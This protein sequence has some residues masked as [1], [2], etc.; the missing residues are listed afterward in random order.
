MFYE[1]FDVEKVV[2]PVNVK[3]LKQL[4]IESNYDKKE[5]DFLISGFTHGFSLGYEG[6]FDVKLRA[7]N[8]RLANETEEILLWNKVMKEVKE[9]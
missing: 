6:S 3:V 2:T 9:K 7:P 5:T 4:L 1:N 8:L